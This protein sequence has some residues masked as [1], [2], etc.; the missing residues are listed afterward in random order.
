[1]DI[2]QKNETKYFHFHSAKIRNKFL[3]ILLGVWCREVYYFV[4]Q[5]I[6]VL[7]VV[8]LFPP[9]KIQTYRFEKTTS[10]VSKFYPAKRYK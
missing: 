3:V 10:A 2:E 6:S 9:L 1:M 7:D 5:H 8:C 4:M